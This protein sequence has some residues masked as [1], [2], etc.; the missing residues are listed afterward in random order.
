MRFIRFD[1][2]ASP[3]TDIRTDDEVFVFVD[4]DKRLKRTDI[5]HNVK[6]FAYTDE[7]S[8]FTPVYEKDEFGTITANTVIHEFDGTTDYIDSPGETAYF[9]YTDLYDPQPRPLYLDGDLIKSTIYPA[10]YGINVRL[11]TGIFAWDESSTL[12]LNAEQDWA[13]GPIRH[14]FSGFENSV[15]ELMWHFTAFFPFEDSYLRLWVVPAG[16]SAYHFI[17]SNK[18][19]SVRVS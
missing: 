18:I 12:R 1:K 14:D 15:D 8:G 16:F 9:T 13:F 6:T 19:W 3:P 4:N 5:D 10:C 17:V 11:D 2:R 7:V